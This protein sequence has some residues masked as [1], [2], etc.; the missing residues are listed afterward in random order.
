MLQFYQSIP[1]KEI[2]YL[3]SDS[4]SKILLV[5]H[6][7]LIGRYKI[8]IICVHDEMKMVSSNLK[9]KRDVDSAVYIIYT[10]GTTGEPKGVVISNKKF[11]EFSNMATERRQYK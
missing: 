8:P 11:A 6:S 1:K 2:E 9:C 4:K 5:S 3:L 7:D 10:S